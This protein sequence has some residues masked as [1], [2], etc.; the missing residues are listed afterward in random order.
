MYKFI[1]MYLYGFMYVL[2]LYDYVL[3]YVGICIYDGISTLI[4]YPYFNATV[5][6]A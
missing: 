6:H 4:I 3:Y 2:S 5:I 1:Y